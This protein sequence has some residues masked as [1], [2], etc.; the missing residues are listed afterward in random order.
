V[1]AK[2][3]TS[4][5]KATAHLKQRSAEF[6][7][8]PETRFGTWFQG[9]DI[10]TR[11]VLCEALD[12]LKRLAADNLPEQ[13][14][15]LDAGCGTG[16]AFPL[17]NERFAPSRMIAIDIEPEYIGQAEV[18][19][20]TAGCPID[21]LRGDVSNTGLADSSIDVIV[22]HQTLHHV[23]KQEKTL[24][25][26]R[27][28]LKPGGML[29]LAESCQSFTESFLVRTLFRHPVGN[30]QSA[31]NYIAMVKAA[32]FEIA[33]GCSSTPDPWWARP[34][35]GLWHK[36]G[37]KKETVATQVCVAAILPALLYDHDIATG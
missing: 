31:D 20:I 13:P 18:A 35:M 11:Y 30:Q 17:I 22:C 15:I 12:E 16:I 28:L 36:L 1:A 2:R 33:P 4:G 9:T 8:V 25:E 23:S 14:L 7:W 21:A 29:L 5:A 19:A 6:D 37:L 10:W 24:G 34:A 3:V 27:R 32:G 26:F